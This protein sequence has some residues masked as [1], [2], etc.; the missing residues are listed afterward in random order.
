MF[1]AITVMR[2]DGG[3]SAGDF[4][5]AGGF[6]G[7]EVRHV[8]EGYLVLLPDVGDYYVGVVL[9]VLELVV[10]EKGVGFGV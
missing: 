10:G 9:V 4:G 8:V 2:K 7:G 1:D 3:A 6:G 5:G